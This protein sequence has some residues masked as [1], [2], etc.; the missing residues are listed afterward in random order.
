MVLLYSKSGQLANRLWQAAYFIS[1]ALEYNYSLLHL[2]FTDYS[3]YFQESLSSELKELG[4]DIRIK[5]VNTPL[6]TDRAVI[7]YAAVSNRLKYNLP[8]IREIKLI[9]NTSKYDISQASFIKLAKNKILLVDGWRF[10]DYLA[11]KKHAETIRTLFTPNG[12]FLENTFTLRKDQFKKFD[13][14]IGVHIR[15]GDYA[16]FLQGRWFYSL[17]TYKEFMNQVSH[18]PQFKNMRLGFYIC[19]N[20]KVNLE[21]FK[22]FNIVKSSNHFI[23]D[24]HGLSSC[25]L[26]IGPPSTYSAWAAF[27][28]KVPL[29]FLQQKEMKLHEKYI[30]NFCETLSY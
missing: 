22:D 23:E 10:V 24:L 5:D 16:R 9:S 17:E 29:L 15:L 2:G 21:Y 7:R 11:L 13:K 19:S 28:G 26:I 14:I 1:N 25:D 18:F 6:L 27:Y 8:F 4:K 20:E 3:K 30:E 12:V